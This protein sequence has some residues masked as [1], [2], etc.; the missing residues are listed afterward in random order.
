MPRI[1]AMG[2]EHTFSSQQ[3]KQSVQDAWA[4]R[5]FRR[6]IFLFS[7]A[8]LLA[9]TI[10][11]TLAIWATT[12]HGV[13]DGIGVLA[14]NTCADIKRL[15]AG[16]HVLINTLSTILLAGS[17][18]CMQCLS[19]PTRSQ[20]DE[21]HK[22]RRWMDIGVHS[23]RNTLNIFHPD[24]YHHVNGMRVFLWLLLALSSLPLHLLYAKPSGCPEVMV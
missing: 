3:W 1:D 24:A 9:F 11:L 8:A 21:A 17:N 22:H 5:G 16:V 7:G 4:R 19:A 12:S 20:I 13:E 18:Y 6:S 23:I 2:T 14:E 10:N 15:N